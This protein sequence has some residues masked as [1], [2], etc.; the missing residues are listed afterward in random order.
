M[1]INELFEREQYILSHGN[2]ERRWKI[3]ISNNRLRFTI[4][5][6]NG[7][8]DLDSETILQKNILYNISVSYSGSELEIYINGKLDA[9]KYYQWRFTLN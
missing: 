8:V 1:K 3:S 6:T 5:T 9:F 7:I 2:W 4:K